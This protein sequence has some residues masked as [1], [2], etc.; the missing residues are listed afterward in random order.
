MC[1]AGVIYQVDPVSQEKANSSNSFEA[2]PW[3]HAHNRGMRTLPSF[4]TDAPVFENTF[5][6]SLPGESHAKPGVRQ[7]QNAAY[8]R[9]SP[10]PV[11]APRLLA[12]SADVAELL[13]FPADLLAR[14]CYDPGPWTALLSGNTVAPTSQS[15][16]QAYGGHQ[17]GTWAG[18]LGDGRVIVLG[19][20]V[21]ASGERYE[22]QLK[23]AGLTPYSRSADG[24]AVLRSSLREYLC[25][26]AM[27]FLGVPTSR[28][29]SL[30][31]TGD[32][33][34]R[35]MFYDGHAAEEPGAI[36]CRVAPSFIRF[37]SFQFHAWREQHDL[38]RALADYT[39]K[40][41]FPELGAPSRETFVEFFREVC[42][43]T[44][45]MVTAW[46]RVGFVHGVMNTDNMSVHGLTIDYGPYG[47][48]D[49]FDPHWTPNTT[50]HATHR[51]AFGR[52]PRI[53]EWNLAAFASSL[54][55]L[56]GETAP[57]EE[58]LGVYAKTLT[59]SQA[60]MLAEKLGLQDLDGEDDERLAEELFALLTRVETDMTL[61]FRALAYVPE[62]DDPMEPLR[63]AFYADAIPDD[64][65][66]AWRAWFARYRKR[67]ACDARPTHQRR[68][69]MNRANPRFVLRNY[70]AQTAIEAAT[71][72]D[73]APLKKL[74]GA[75]RR[76][77]D[78]Q[79]EHRE[80]MAKRPEWAR[81]KPGCSALSCS[82]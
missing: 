39:L 3:C 72:G 30:V 60:A 20:R 64:V 24:R 28:S 12:F 50:D 31:A 46:M 45:R 66:A 49:N 38:L 5:V 32:A 77:Y 59:E 21:S 53:A 79:P 75:L 82:S 73:L 2:R 61:F 9:V 69:A 70:L 40:T 33:V 43:R 22:V 48:I 56:I 78:E 54:V 76:P 7:V 42:R 4:E 52:Q 11:A 8:S 71:E 19:E 80:L 15:Y 25:A 36:V 18:Q 1:P 17:F 14:E 27:H 65:T 41:H 68:A 47:W 81:T 57:L 58:A 34:L 63:D 62:A 26:E 35:D 37:G 16:A 74:E 23:G 29:L 10:T 51:Y 67:I 13:R 44:A 55:P 6:E